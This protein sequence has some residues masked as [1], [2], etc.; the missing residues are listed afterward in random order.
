M[1]ADFRVRIKH[2]DMND[3]EYKYFD[4]EKEAK[5]WCIQ[6]SEYYIR[7]LDSYECK[8]DHYTLYQIQY[9]DAMTKEY[10]PDYSITI[11]QTE[12]SV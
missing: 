8:S 9:L 2:Y 12:F 6:R 3:V 10:V 7:C 4:T 11:N 1:A 5:A